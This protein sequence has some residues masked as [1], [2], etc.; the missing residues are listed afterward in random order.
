[1]FFWEILIFTFIKLLNHKD[2]GDYKQ[3][4]LQY[5]QNPL[6]LKK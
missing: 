6:K 2:G 3:K 4:K 1:M 5:V